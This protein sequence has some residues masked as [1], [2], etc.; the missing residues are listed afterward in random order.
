M[1]TRSSL[2]RRGPGTRR[3]PRAISIE[4][5]TTFGDPPTFS[6]RTTLPDRRQRLN[7]SAY[8]PNKN[9][10][11]LAVTFRTDPVKEYAYVK[12][13]E[14]GATGELKAQKAE[15]LNSLRASGTVSE[16]DVQQSEAW[17]QDT[18]EK[19]FHEPLETDQPPQC[20]EPAS[21]SVNE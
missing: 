5:S 13:Q 17:A 2:L 21:A 3:P 11:L 6:G 19:Y 14:L 1:S 9:R 4:V 16:A 20:F 12:L 15:R 7:S 18:F 10:G 8:A